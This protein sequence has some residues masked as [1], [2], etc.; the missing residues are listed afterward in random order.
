[1]SL[2]FILI[3]YLVFVCF[4]RY[5]TIVKKKKIKL[6]HWTKLKNFLFVFMKCE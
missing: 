1:M 2:T 6:S 4:A 5:F 3:S